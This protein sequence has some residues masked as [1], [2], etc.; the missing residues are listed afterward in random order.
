MLILLADWLCGY[1]HGIT[2]PK[3]RLPSLAGWIGK[4]QEVTRS[5]LPPTR[6][7]F[8]TSRYIKL[9]TWNY[10]YIHVTEIAFP[11]HSDLNIIEAL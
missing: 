1:Y 9:R 11:P 10:D 5:V 8:Y 7:N 2:G 6:S 3:R 4:V